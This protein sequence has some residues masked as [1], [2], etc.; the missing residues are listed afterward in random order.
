M[1]RFLRFFLFHRFAFALFSVLSAECGTRFARCVYL[2]KSEQKNKKAAN[3]LTVFECPLLTARNTCDKIKRTVSAFFVVC[4][5][6]VQNAAERQKR[7][8]FCK[9]QKM[10]DYLIILNEDWVLAHRGDDVLPCDFVENCLQE[11]WTDCVIRDRAA[12]YLQAT[13]DCCKNDVAEFL[14]QRLACYDDFCADML[15]IVDLDGE[16]E[17]ANRGACQNTQT[18]SD[19]DNVFQRVDQL[20]SGAEFKTFAQEFKMFASQPNGNLAEVI[21]SQRYL[22]SIGDGCGLETYLELLRD[23]LISLKLPNLHVQKDVLTGKIPLKKSLPSDSLLKDFE[24][25]RFGTHVVCVDISEWM[26]KA[27]EEFRSVVQDLLKLCRNDVIV[28]CV[29]FVDK[30]VL[31]N[32]GAALNDLMFVRKLSFPPLSAEEI[33]LYA[34]KEAARFGFTLHEDALPGIRRRMAL[35]SADGSFHGIDTVNKVVRELLY[36]KHLRNATE[37]TSDFVVRA[38]DA[39]KLCDDDGDDCTGLEMLNKLVGTESIKQRVLEIISQ[40]KLVRKNDKLGTPCLHM[41]FVGNPGTGKTTVARIVGKILKEN[42]ILRIGEFHEHKGRDFCGTFVGETAPKTSGICRNAYGSVLFIDE[43]YSLYQGTNGSYDFGKEALDTLVAEM[44]NHRNDFVVIMAGYSDEMETLMR[45]NPGL[46]GRVPYTVEFP[47]FT[48]SQLYEIFCSMA[49]DKIDCDRDFLE[50]ARN[51]FMN[52][53]EEFLSS[54]Q[55]SNARFVRNLFERCCAKAAMRSQLENL[56]K[57]SLTKDDF[58]RSVTDTE[59]LNAKKKR[60]I[61]FGD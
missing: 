23:M 52:L 17:R 43:A 28:F 61:G 60:K 2:Q 11:H 32:V 15:Q 7:G 13:V 16:S 58:C 36:F 19:V 35:E 50:T 53:D 25:K 31:D 21:V 37:G 42:G 27:D 18:P 41:K 1:R 34:Q 54:K 45:G 22:F 24:G 38:R 3:A 30:E 6:V 5:G 14:A 57:T 12:S 44:E 39:A 26:S 48:R 46:A 59:F 29:P 9:G 49:K 40:I 56:Q 47:N 10:R 4:F 51:Y 20:I 8:R 55:F 33:I